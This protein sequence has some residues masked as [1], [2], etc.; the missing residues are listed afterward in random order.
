MRPVKVAQPTRSRPLPSASYRPPKVVTKRDSDIRTDSDYHMTKRTDSMV[1]ATD[2]D[3]HITTH[4]SPVTTETSMP[5]MVRASKGTLTVCLGPPVLTPP[6]GCVGAMECVLSIG[7]LLNPQSAAALRYDVGITLADGAFTTTNPSVQFTM[8]PVYDTASYT[9][10]ARLCCSDPSDAGCSMFASFH[11]TVLVT[12]PTTEDV[13]V[14]GATFASPGL[15]QYD[16]SSLIGAIIPGGGSKRVPVV[17]YLPP[18]D[19]PGSTGRQI[20]V[21]ITTSDANEYTD[22]ET[23]S[24]SQLSLPQ[25]L[26]QY[27]I[28]LAGT[29]GGTPIGPDSGIISPPSILSQLD[30]PAAQTYS[31]VWELYKGDCT[32]T[33][34]VNSIEQTMTLTRAI[35]TPRW[36]IVGSNL[37]AYIDQSAPLRVTTAYIFRATYDDGYTVDHASPIVAISPSSQNVIMP[38]T[39]VAHGNLRLIHIVSTA[40][41]PSVTVLAPVCT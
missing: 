6:S 41:T 37:W 11:S 14:V 36:R 8:D 30:G 19:E 22:G 7:A 5:G 31:Y 29:S 18:C 21:I 17:G 32:S 3:G 28:K 4:L 9:S 20:T 34:L 13:T 12:N 27:C 2:A 23:V 1:Q 15:Y 35:I 39:M 16:I 10:R 38:L 26:N 24:C 40:V 25:C 33:N